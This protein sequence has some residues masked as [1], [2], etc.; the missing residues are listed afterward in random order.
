MTIPTTVI[1]IAALTA[2][3]GLLAACPTATTQVDRAARA[4][5]LKNAPYDK[6]LVVGVTY[7]KDTGRAFEKVLVEELAN[8]DTRA[9]AM[10]TVV[11]TTEVTE[12]VVRSAAEKVDADAVLIATVENVETDVKFGNRRVDLKERPQNGGLVDFFRH[13]YEEVTSEPSVDLKFTAVVVS[14]VYDVESGNRIYTVESATANAS[15]AEEI[16]V[17]ESAA[18]VLRMHKDGIIR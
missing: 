12:D 6:I 8:Y 17:Q 14:D 16:I 9:S 18:I 2:T 13:E 15:S 7:R 3:L 5:V 10:H 11:S 4:K 1:R